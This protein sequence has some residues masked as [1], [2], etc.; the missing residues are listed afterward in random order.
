MIADPGGGNAVLWLVSV[1]VIWV[2][3]GLPMYGI[4]MKADKPGWAG[5][6]PI[7]NMVVMLEIVGRPVWWLLLYFIPI[8]NVVIL[9]IVLLD[10]ARSFGKGT[11]FAI[12][13]IFLSWIF[14]LILGFGSAT[15]QG[16]AAGGSASAAPPPPPPPPS[17]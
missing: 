17:S 16:P 12:G 9:I 6:V 4:F 11:G 7:Y 10:L 15:Y 14:M 1:V 2:L 3:I 5:F 8:V 13:L